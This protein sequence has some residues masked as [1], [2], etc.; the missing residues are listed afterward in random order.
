MSHPV[1][2]V[3]KGILHTVSYF[4]FFS[5][6]PTLAELHRFHH[7][8]IQVQ[9]I[10][11]AVQDLTESGR[12]VV[13]RGRV[14]QSNQVLTTTRLRQE[15][16]EQI[17]QRFVESHLP[18]FTWIPMIRFIGISG[19]LSMRNIKEDADIDLFVITS[20]DTVWLTRSIILVV[21]HILSRIPIFASRPLCWNIIMSESDLTL[22]PRKQNEYAAHELLQ[23]NMV[24]QRRDTHIALLSANRWIFQIF[25]NAQFGY[26]KVNI[27]SR[28]SL[29]SKTLRCIDYLLSIPQRFWLKKKK[30]HVREIG[31]QLWFIQ[32]DIE[33]KIPLKLKRI[34]HEPR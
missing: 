5:Y 17:F 15:S 16:S 20:E 13:R 23:L 28:L 9:D 14:A 8:S 32:D 3:E 4:E 24:F 34:K 1:D 31:S 25:P 12:L 27:P 11:Q 19:S 22:P 33:P 21:S 2:H 7:T 10:K 29:Q 18:F 6:A 26:I 30:Y